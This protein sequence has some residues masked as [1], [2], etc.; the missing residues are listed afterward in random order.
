M[1]S[2]KKRKVITNTLQRNIQTFIEYIFL[3]SSHAIKP[4]INTRTF[5]LFKAWEI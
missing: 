3:F 5:K 4:K 2:N 1:L